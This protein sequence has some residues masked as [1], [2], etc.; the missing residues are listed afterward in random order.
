M[1]DINIINAGNPD[2]VIDEIR[3][4]KRI[5]T[6]EDHNIHGGLGAYISKL[7]V[8]NAP[9]RVSRIG[10]STFGE[11]GPADVLADQYGFAPHKIA[12]VVELGMR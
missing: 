2:K 7:V 10:L 6:V 12:E 9:M 11:S 5:V 3:K 4:A 1:G 8:E